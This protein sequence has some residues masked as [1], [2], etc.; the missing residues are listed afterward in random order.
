MGEA[1]LNFLPAVSQRAK[2]EMR[3]T[4]RAWRLKWCVEKTPED[5]SKMFNP[6]IRGWVNYYGKYY[7]SA[8]FPLSN[9]IDLHLAAWL[10][11][12][13]KHYRRKPRKAMHKLGKL[14]RKSTYLFAHWKQLDYLPAD[15]T[16]RAV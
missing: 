13:Y 6:I 11:N 10:M 16:R 8:L 2:K 3:G 12:K 5:L 15:G 4:V 14:A 1:I 9:H 7:K